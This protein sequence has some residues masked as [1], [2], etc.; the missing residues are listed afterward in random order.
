MAFSLEHLSKQQRLIFYPLILIPMLL[1]VIGIITLPRERP[2]TTP[3]Q[4]NDQMTPGVKQTTELSENDTQ[5]RSALLETFLPESKTSGVVFE[6]TNVR[7]EY[8]EPIDGFLGEILTENITEA[9]DE[10]INWF[11]SQGISKEGICTL[12]INFYLNKDVRD[13]LNEISTEFNLLPPGC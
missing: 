9:K 1:A 12:P 13:S 8:V 7:V 5:A 10:A 11:L 4:S 2:N 6:S 3:Q